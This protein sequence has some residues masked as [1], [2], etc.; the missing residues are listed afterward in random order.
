MT[1]AAP[2]LPPDA[3]RRNSGATTACP[4]T[5][6]L[7]VV[8]AGKKCHRHHPRR[9]RGPEPAARRVSAGRLEE[10]SSSS[11]S[12]CTSQCAAKAT[13]TLPNLPLKRRPDAA[14]K[15]LRNTT[16]A[17]TKLESRIAAGALPALPSLANERDATTT[18]S[19]GGMP[20]PPRA[21]PKRR[22]V[23]SRLE[24]ECRHNGSERPLWK[25]R[26]GNHG[27]GSARA[28][29]AAAAGPVKIAAGPVKI[30]CCPTVS[31]LREEAFA[32]LR[33]MARPGLWRGPLHRSEEL[34]AAL[35]QLDRLKDRFKADTK[36]RPLSTYLQLYL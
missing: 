26:R 13:A 2:W 16:A 30:W 32:D 1:C 19:G 23:H 27:D 6:K 18:P 21:A 15:K 34:N 4:Q 14:S 22:D 33:G 11:N 8:A 5:H 31:S 36:V 3:A 12:G 9:S 28:G 17:K 29:G 24:N 25:Q 20:P 10:G 7:V 35:L